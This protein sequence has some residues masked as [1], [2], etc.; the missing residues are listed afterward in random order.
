MRHVLPRLPTSCL[1]KWTI[2]GYIIGTRRRFRY[3]HIHQ[4]LNFHRSEDVD[5]AYR[6]ESS[7]LVSQSLGLYDCNLVADTLVGIKVQSEL[8]IVFFN[9]DP[10]GPLD[11]FGAYT[12][13]HAV[14]VSASLG[15]PVSTVC[16]QEVQTANI[17]RSSGESAKICI[18]YSSVIL[19]L[20]KQQS[21]QFMV[22]SAEHWGHQLEEAHHLA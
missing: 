2:G 17:P 1:I 14:A 15:N 10:R 9:E 19:P 5:A 18:D 12:T 21:S 7:Y 22:I 11:S 6:C 8:L 20:I 4:F 13:L 3:Q 16:L